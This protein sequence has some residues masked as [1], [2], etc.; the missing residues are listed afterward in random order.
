LG[1]AESRRRL[2]TAATV[3][4]ALLP[5][6]ASAAILVV[7]PPLWFGDSG[8]TTGL[9]VGA[10]VFACY[11]V[12]FNLIFG[13]TN[14][15]FLC[16]GALAGV[17]G[18]AAA[19]LA[20]RASLPLA[21]GIAVGTASAAIVGGVLSFIAVR[22]SLD[23]IFTGIV[24]LVF[25]LGFSD[26]LAGQRD[27]TGGDTGR[28]ITGAADDLADNRLGGYYLF[29]GVLVGFLIVFRA[30]QLSHVGWA[31]RALRDDETAAELAGVDV[32]RYRIYAAVLGSAMIGLTGGLYA[33]SAGFISPATYSFGEVDVSVLVLVAFGGLGT[34]LGPV[35]GAAVFA[36]VDQRLTSSGQTRD[37]IYGVFVIAIFLFFRQGFVPTLV[38]L[39]RRFWGRGSGDVAGRRPLEHTLAE[40]GATVAESGTRLDP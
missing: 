29:V 2:G 37:L 34:L 4:R 24:T 19:I 6:A 40:E 11:G 14:Q 33:Y 18:Y 10:L 15:L 30:L 13:S 32:A 38:T 21:A 9:A 25:A 27:L 17:G 31:F 3:G 16:V 1:G 7:L 5:I 22:R 26:L 36:F 8:Y 12:G 28:I 35:V 39:V 23:V 20:D